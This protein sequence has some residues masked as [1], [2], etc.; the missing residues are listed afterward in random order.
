MAVGREFRQSAKLTFASSMS[1]PGLA[2][3]GLALIFRQG[4]VAQSLALFGCQIG[5]AGAEKHHEIH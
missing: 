4:Q 1:W 5:E 3:P 2:W